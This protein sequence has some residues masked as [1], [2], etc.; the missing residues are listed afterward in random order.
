MK[1]FQVSRIVAVQAIGNH[2]CNVL[3]AQICSKASEI[4]VK[5]PPQNAG[6][7]ETETLTSTLHLRHILTASRHIVI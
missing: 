7:H 5:A 4:Y 2:F 6:V 3:Y 1:I